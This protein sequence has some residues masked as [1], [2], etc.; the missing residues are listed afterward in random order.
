[1]YHIQKVTFNDDVFRGAC[2]AVAF[3]V[4]SS[5]AILTGTIAAKQKN[6]N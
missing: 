2:S 4:A 6:K 3:A 5:V 1:M